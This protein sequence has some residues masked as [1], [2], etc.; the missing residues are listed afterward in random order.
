MSPPLGSNGPNHD[1]RRLDVF[2]PVHAENQPHNHRHQT[3]PPPPGTHTTS[4]HVPPPPFTV[5]TRVPLPASVPPS[6]F[7]AALRAYTPLITANAHLVSFTRT[8]IDLAA[9]VSDPFFR[10]DD[11]AAHLQ[12]FLIHQRIPILGP[13]TSDVAVP[14][15]FQSF[16]AGTRCRADASAGV[17]VR[18]SYEVRPRRG[19]AEAGDEWVPPGPRDGEW[20][21]VEVADV[22]CGVLVRPFVR[23]SLAGSHLELL[24]KLVADV[25]EEYH[26]RKEGQVPGVA[27]GRPV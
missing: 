27:P 8:P 19:Q 21:V 7:L 22:E 17:T 4:Q 13:F 20:E 1:I 2:L 18:S 23:R 26:G 10:T 3:H 25:A 14:C 5:T 16:D 12:A 11:G 24:T 6:V 15:V 9:I